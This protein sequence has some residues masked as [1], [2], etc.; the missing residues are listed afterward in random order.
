MASYQDV[1]K[2]WN[3]N[4]LG[5]SQQAY[6]N[7]VMQQAGINQG[8]MT[9]ELQ[10]QLDRLGMFYNKGQ[11]GKARGAAE[12]FRSTAMPMIA[13]QKANQPWAE[14]GQ[15]ALTM[16]QNLLGL[17]GAE[18]MNSAY[19]ENPAHQFAQ[20][21]MEQ[22]LMRNASA[23]GGL[24]GSD[25]QRELAQYTS[26]LTNQNIQNQLSQLGFMNEQGRMATGNIGDAT[27]GQWIDQSSIQSRLAEQR[28]VQR[29]AKGSGLQR[30][31]GMVGGAL[32]L[33]S[34]IPSG[35]AGFQQ[36]ANW[37]SGIGQPNPPAPAGGFTGSAG[38]Y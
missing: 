27:A 26:G 16:Q 25:V 29:A 30:G 18:A 7:Q 12:A 21:Q 32:Q 23:T 14:S 36:G 19:M 9:P 1:I 35:I 22:A 34:M 24:R 17:N 37:L 10:A 3:Q 28:A 2:S 15:K 8:Q 13:Q 4:K 31:L 6:T 38:G 33:G 20:S 5:T 11:V